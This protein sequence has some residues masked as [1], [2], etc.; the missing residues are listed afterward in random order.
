VATTTPTAT[1]AAM[2]EVGVNFV[3][4]FIISIN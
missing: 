4:I 2:G 1:T 3:E